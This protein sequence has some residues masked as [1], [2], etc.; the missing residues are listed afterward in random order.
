MNV[1]IDHDDINVTAYRLM[2]TEHV[3]SSSIIL[4]QLYL[5]SQTDLSLFNWLL[6]RI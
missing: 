6:M 3:L 4:P 5:Y 2:F 1:V